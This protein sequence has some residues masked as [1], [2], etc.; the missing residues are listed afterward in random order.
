MFS[1]KQEMRNARLD[2]LIRQALNPI[3]PATEIPRT[4]QGNILMGN[5]LMA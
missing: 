1:R 2:E 4:S 3:F 5:L